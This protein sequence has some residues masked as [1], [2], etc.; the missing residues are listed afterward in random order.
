MKIPELLAEELLFNNSDGVKAGL[1]HFELIAARIPQRG[2][3]KHPQQRPLFLLFQQ[4]RY[5]ARGVGIE[6]SHDVRKIDRFIR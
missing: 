1:P 6:I 2:F 5:L 4:L 3:M